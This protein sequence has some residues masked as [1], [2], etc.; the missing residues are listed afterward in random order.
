[1]DLAGVKEP[2]GGAAHPFWFVLY[3][4]TMLGLLVYGFRALRIL[5][6]RSPIGRASAR[7]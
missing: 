2:A 1:L 6:W 3:A 7:G 5:W 4:A